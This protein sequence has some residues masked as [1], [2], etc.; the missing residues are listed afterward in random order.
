MGLTE[1]EEVMADVKEDVPGM[2]GDDAGNAHVEVV[3]VKHKEEVV[4]YDGRED[5]FPFKCSFSVK[6]A[7]HEDA[8]VVRNTMIVDGE[9]N[10]GKVLREID[11]NDCLL[12][13]SF[14]S[15]EARLLRAVLSTFMDVLILATRTIEKFGGRSSLN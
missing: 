10:P 3:G 9:L 8:N 2:T 4:E 6:Y 5:K 13:V 14:R 11:V 1:R 7:S 12:N 15:A